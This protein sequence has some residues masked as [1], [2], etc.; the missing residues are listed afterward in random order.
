MYL[1]LVVN[2]VAKLEIDFFEYYDLN[3]EAVRLAINDISHGTLITKGPTFSKTRGSIQL[4]VNLRHVQHLGN[5]I[6]CLSYTVLW[7]IL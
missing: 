4:L 2:V 7:I 1:S 3:K 5:F 6:F